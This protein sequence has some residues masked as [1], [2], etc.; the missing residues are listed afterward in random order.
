MM[1][2]WLLALYAFE[3]TTCTHMHAHRHM[4]MHEN[5]HSHLNM[6][7]EANADHV[8]FIHLRRIN[9]FN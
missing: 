4:H 6:V 2:S 1:I 7:R 8:V 9:I 5:I 3:S